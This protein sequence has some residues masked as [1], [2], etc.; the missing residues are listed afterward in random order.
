[1]ECDAGTPSRMVALFP[2]AQTHEEYHSPCSVTAPSHDEEYA[3]R[4]AATA[5]AEAAETRV[6]ELE[7]RPREGR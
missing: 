6:A 7:A 3:A 1:M 2:V 4:Q 5:R